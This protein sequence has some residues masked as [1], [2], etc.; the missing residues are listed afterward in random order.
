M[1]RTVSWLWSYNIL[2][3]SLISRLGDSAC[4]ELPATT[5]CSQHNRHNGVTSKTMQHLEQDHTDAN[6][7]LQGT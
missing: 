6:V 5:T 7:C 2:G 3:Y 1:E 4:S